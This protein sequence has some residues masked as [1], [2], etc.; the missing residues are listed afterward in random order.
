MREKKVSLVK[1]KNSKNS[2]FE[3]RLFRLPRV[4]K[5]NF[6]SVGERKMFEFELEKGSKKH[7]CPACSN[8]TFVRVKSRIT[9]DYL[10]PEVGRCD[11]ESKCG[12]EY[13][14]KHFFLDNSQ[15]TDKSG[16]Y[17]KGK[18]Q[19]IQTLALSN[20]NGSQAIY[21][22]DIL[23]KKP[24][25]IPNEYFLQ[26]LTD[27]ASN[28]FV[29]FLLNLFPEDSALVKQAVKDY[30]IGAY[31]DYT[32]FAYIDRQRRV[33]RIKLIRFNAQ[34]GKRLKGEYDTSS[35]VAKLKRQGKVK[36]D[37]QYKQNFFGEHLLTDNQKPIA[38]VEAEK[39]ALIASI[40]FPAFVWLAAG[41]KQ[42]LKAERLKRLETNRQIVL[43]PDADG[44]LNWQEI[45]FKA[46]FEGLNIKVSNIIETLGTEAEKR[47]GFDLA[48]YL[49]AEI[50][51]KNTRRNAFYSLVINPHFT[52][53]T[54]ASLF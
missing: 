9:N 13:T 31:E 37:F 25:Y 46:R 7:V 52:G 53:W 22:A 38:I 18:K 49:I 30:F 43:Y 5:R 39:T 3:I 41:S 21:Q 12:Y 20:K 40:C 19:S 48:D 2:K 28:A 11:R 44:Y 51:E 35:L 14:Y 4:S 26:T 27:Y 47:E 10:P 8:K 32:S 24:D 42:W 29:Q 6:F 36:A 15:K 17:K 45:A 54:N 16:H 1:S 34:T 50:K 23:P 33:C